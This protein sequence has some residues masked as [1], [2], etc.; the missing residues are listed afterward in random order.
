MK[1]LIFV[2]SIFV[3]LISLAA[4]SPAADDSAE[5]YTVASL[6]D[7]ANGKVIRITY[8]LNE[9]VNVECVESGA[10]IKVNRGKWE[11][12]A[13][14]QIFWIRA[15]GEVMSLFAALEAS[16]PEPIEG[17]VRIFEKDGKKI[18]EVYKDASQI[19]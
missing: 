14:D 1:R 9:I 12:F 2:L 11:P 17:T 5:S 15:N 3:F 8:P 18:L 13:K 4:C 10:V 19:P 16:Y 7:M 6:E